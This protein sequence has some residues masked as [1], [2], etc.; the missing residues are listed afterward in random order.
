MN[1]HT[2]PSI[3]PQVESEESG[4][5]MHTLPPYVYGVERLFLLN[6]RKNV[7]FWPEE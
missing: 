1:N 3:F 4:G 7:K 5:R 6:L 2:I